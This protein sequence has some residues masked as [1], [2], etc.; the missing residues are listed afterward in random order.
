[1]IRSKNLTD[2]L[3]LSILAREGVGAIWALY[4]TAAEAY[5]TG[6]PHAAAAIIEIAE[7]TERASLAANQ[8]LRGRLADV[9]ASL[10]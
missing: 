8:R 9:I 7:A 10:S 2:K 5:R 6:H 3:A 4:V 1:M